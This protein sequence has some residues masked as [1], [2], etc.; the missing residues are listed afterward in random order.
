[1]MGWLLILIEAFSGTEERRK[2]FATAANRR[3]SDSQAQ[4]FTVISKVRIID[5]HPADF[6]PG[7]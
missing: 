7:A 5:R 3:T 4:E 2:R 6:L 1:M